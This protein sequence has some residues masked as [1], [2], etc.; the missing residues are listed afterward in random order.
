MLYGDDFVKYQ[1]EGGEIPSEGQIVYCSGRM[2]KDM[3]W[4][5]KMSIQDYKIYSRL[6]ELKNDEN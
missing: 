3:G 1:R 5:K 6:T 2:G 4:L